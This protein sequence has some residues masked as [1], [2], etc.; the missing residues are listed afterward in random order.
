M[1]SLQQHDQ[2]FLMEGKPQSNKQRQKEE[3]TPKEYDYESYSQG[4]E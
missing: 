1:T 2:I 4:S 3:I